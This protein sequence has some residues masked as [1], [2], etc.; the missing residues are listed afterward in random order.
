ML[1]IFVLSI[2]TTTIASVGIYLGKHVYSEIVFCLF[3][4]VAGCIGAIMG[5]W[6]NE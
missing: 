1:K 5:T 2:I 4:A 6:N 3:G